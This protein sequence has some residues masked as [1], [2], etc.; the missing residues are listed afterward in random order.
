MKVKKLQS[1]LIVPVV[2]KRKL[3]RFKTQVFFCG[4]EKEV[5]EFKNLVLKKGG[6]FCG[7]MIIDFLNVYNEPVTK[8]YCCIYQYYEEIE[9]EVYT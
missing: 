7:S 1:G 3:P 4:Y 8:Q 6:Y 2:P 9:M 5:E